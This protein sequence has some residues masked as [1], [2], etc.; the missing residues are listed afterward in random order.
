MSD[1]ADLELIPRTV[2]DKLDRVGIKLHLREWQLL[3]LEERRLLRDEPCASQAE[4]NLY[5]ARLTNM[6]QARTGNGPES[7]R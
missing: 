7:L 3:S 2:R 5:R 6:V 1:D 4:V